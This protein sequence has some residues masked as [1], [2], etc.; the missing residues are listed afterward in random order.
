MARAHRRSNRATRKP[1]QERTPVKPEGPFGSQ[2][3][4]VAID[5]QAKATG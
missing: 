5:A 4:R 1:K 3:G 2:I